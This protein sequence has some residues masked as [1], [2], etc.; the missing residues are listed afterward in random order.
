M[1]VLITTADFTFKF[2]LP[3][4]VYSSLDSLITD[5]EEKYLRDLLGATLYASF[6]ANLVNKVPVLPAYLAIYNAFAIDVAPCMIH[7]QGMKEMLKGFIFFDFMRNAK[8]KPTTQGI[9]ANS[10]DTS[11]NIG[12]GNL[13]GFENEAVDTYDVIQY[14]ITQVQPEDYTAIA[15]NGIKKSYSIPFF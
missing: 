11:E 9:V 8:Y 2:A 3:Q 13:F 14:Y 15:F 6:K 7:S 10:S 1:G 4:S 5:T 12:I